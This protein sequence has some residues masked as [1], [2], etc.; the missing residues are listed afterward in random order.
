MAYQDN[1]YRLLLLT[2]TTF[3]L[4][5]LATCELSNKEKEVLLNEHNKLRGMVDPP[6]ANMETMVSQIILDTC[7]I[8]SLCDMTLF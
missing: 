2:V 4:L 6:A 1:C 5:H 8:I 7:S 3:S